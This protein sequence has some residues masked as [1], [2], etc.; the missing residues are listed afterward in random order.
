MDAE[1]VKAAE[2]ALA[3]D[4]GF[5]GTGVQRAASPLRRDAGAAAALLGVKGQRP[6]AGYR[7]QRLSGIQRAAPVAQ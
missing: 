4:A 7:R 6:L 2:I 1:P 3:M 5:A